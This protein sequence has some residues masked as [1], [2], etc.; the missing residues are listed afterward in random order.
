MK[1]DNEKHDCEYNLENLNEYDRSH[2]I[3]HFEGQLK[4]SKDMVMEAIK[5]FDDTHKLMENCCWKEEPIG[6][7]E[8]CRRTFSCRFSGTQRSI[9]GDEI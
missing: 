2:E 8:F 5:H 7:H 3:H 6:T 4:V 1:N 9:G